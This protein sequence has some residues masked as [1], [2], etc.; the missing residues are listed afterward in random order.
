MT[1]C[2]TP[3]ELR[4]RTVTVQYGCTAVFCTGPVTV[5]LARKCACQT[6]VRHT[7]A[8]RI[9][10]SHNGWKRPS[11]ACTV[12]IS[13]VWRSEHRPTRSTC[14]RVRPQALPHPR[15]PPVTVLSTPGWQFSHPHKPAPSPTVCGFFCCH[16][17]Q[18]CFIHPPVPS[19]KPRRPSISVIIAAKSTRSECVRPR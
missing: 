5:P 11:M 3:P 7:A 2:R 13:P 6:A 17:L 16:P 1:K 14:Q 19:L 15:P 9:Q 10:P 8:Y 4:L 12:Q 18:V